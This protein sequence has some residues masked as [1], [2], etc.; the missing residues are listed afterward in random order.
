M[1]NAGFDMLATS[2][3]SDAQLDAVRRLCRSHHVARFELFGS[4]ARGEFD[5]SRSDLDFLVQFEPLCPASRA[6]AYFG[7]LAGLQDLFQRDVDLVETEAITNPYFR[8][9]IDADRTVL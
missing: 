5:I 1:T 2:L 7:L 4:A 6:D 8:Q 9:E 3:I